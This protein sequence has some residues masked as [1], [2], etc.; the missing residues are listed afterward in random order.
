M[1]NET[2]DEAHRL[3][4]ALDE[5]GHETV[6]LSPVGV[7]P[8]LG[9]YLQQLWERRHFIW[10][11]ARHRVATQ[12]S[13][14]RLGNLWLLLRPLLDAAMY[15]VVFALILKVDRGM[16]NF[17][18]FL[19]IGV[20]MFRSTMRSFSTSPQLLHSGKAMIRAFSFPRASL[21]LSAE[22]RDSM[23]MVY[24]VAMVILMIMVIP[25]FERPEL[26]WFLV[27]VIFAFQFVLNLGISLVLARVGFI[28]PDTAQLMGLVGRFMMYGSGVMFPIDR[29]LDNPA[30]TA[31]IQ[32]NPVYHMLQMYREVL[33]DGTVP[34][35][36]SWLILGSWAGALTLFGFLFFW[37]GEAT[38]GGGQ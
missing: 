10:M 32:A 20:L 22:I 34:G 21:V 35:I 24:T 17:P 15:Y 29:F 26:T 12:N 13:R 8:P 19:I 11:D 31:I 1:A 4:T 38:Y 16:E 3:L 9:T 30:A 7:R 37:R 25:P 18:A 36:G 5:R 23:Q 33:I 6:G 28:F 27:P 14:N 2:K